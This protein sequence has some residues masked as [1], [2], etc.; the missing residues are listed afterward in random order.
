MEMQQAGSIVGLGQ[1]G[2]LQRQALYCFSAMAEART[3]DL[4][5]WC[6]PEVVYLGKGRLKCW[7]QYSIAR[8]ARSIGAYRMRREGRE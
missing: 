4:A 6:K 5:A 8:A 3:S 2:R 1:L 7:E